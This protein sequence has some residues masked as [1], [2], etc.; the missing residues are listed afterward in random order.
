MSGGAGA[1]LPGSQSRLSLHP[2][3]SVGGGQHVDDAA[4]VEAIQSVLREV[5]LD[6]VTKKQVRVLVEQRLQTELTGER[7]TFMDRMIDFELA[8]M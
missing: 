6:S 1:G 2:D 7:R 4:I 5:D 8:N 3:L